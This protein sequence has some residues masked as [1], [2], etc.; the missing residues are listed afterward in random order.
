M[1]RIFVFKM[2]FLVL[3]IFTF[4]KSDHSL[5]Q[6]VQITDNI[7][8]LL[9]ENFVKLGS[10]DEGLSYKSNLNSAMLFVYR[11]NV[12]EYDSMSLDQKKDL[13]AINVT[14]FLEPFNGKLLIRKD[15]LIGNLVQSD[16]EF[17]IVN[18][19]LSEYG[20]GKFIAIDNDF[21]CFVYQSLK[22]KL[23]SN[24]DLQVNFFESIKIE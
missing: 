11:L 5:T 24:E 1:K 4:C 17:E 18:P 10:E 21:I 12:P 9:P 14:R 20:V 2:I 6:K 23:K 3:I 22:N 13:M 8:V 15:T 19:T 16:F 7:S